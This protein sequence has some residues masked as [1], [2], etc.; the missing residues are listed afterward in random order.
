MIRLSIGSKEYEIPEGYDELSFSDYC[1]IFFKLGDYV[2]DEDVSELEMF[3][4]SR[5]LEAVIVSRVLHEDDDF[6][7]S[8][9]LNVYAVINEALKYLYDIDSLMKVA[10]ASIIIDGVSYGI[11]SLEE[12]PLRQ[13][14]DADIVMKGEEGE[15]Q[16]IELLAIL[17][18]KRGKDGKF[19]PYDGKYM[20]MMDR[21]KVMSCSDV[22]PL[23]YHFFKRGY[24]FKRLFRVST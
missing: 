18:S 12:M 11:P 20:D 22:L 24:F 23:V 17:L 7:L 13:W 10:S 4:R 2:V 14:I 16:Y 9:P 15:G 5:E 6:A 8:L 19:V 3:R 21:L 1:R